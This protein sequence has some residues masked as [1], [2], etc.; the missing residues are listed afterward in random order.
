MTDND[1]FDERNAIEERG[2]TRSA[3]L[4]EEAAVDSAD[5]AAQAREVLRDS[6]RRAEHPGEAEQRRTPEE[7][8][9]G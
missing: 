2:E 6:E 9:E 4:P 7:T 8:A 3:L 1:S 5:P